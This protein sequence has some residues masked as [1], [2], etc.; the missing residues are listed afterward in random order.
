MAGGRN[1]TRLHPVG[2]A[3][4]SPS[5]SSVPS[6]ERVLSLRNRERSLMRHS[7]ASGSASMTEG[8]KLCLCDRG[9]KGGGG[10]GG[11]GR[12]SASTEA[13][14]MPPAGESVR[15]LVA[16]A[17]VAQA[18]DDGQAAPC[19]RSTDDAGSA[20]R[21]GEW[22]VLNESA[23]ESNRELQ[24]SVGSVFPLYPPTRNNLLA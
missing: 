9:N 11:G 7:C 10:G 17:A 8:I 21:S 18:D 23:R 15:L 6:L 19:A 1:P 2:G 13:M 12:S 3:F 16:D 4:E 24:A 5:S 14:K 22:S 20:N